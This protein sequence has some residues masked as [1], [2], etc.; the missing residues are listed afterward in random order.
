MNGSHDV[1]RAGAVGDGK[2]L[3]TAALQR[4]I[5]ACAD[6]GGGTVRV[7]AGIYRTGTL[8]LKSRVT[9]HLEAGATLLASERREDY[10]P[11]D[12]HPENPVF[13]REMVTGAHLIIAYRQQQVA[14]VGEGTIDGNGLAFFEPL[15][16]GEARA[17]Y[18]DKHRNFTIR[19]WRPGQ[20]IWGCLCTDVALRDVTLRN[21]PYWTCFLH[22]CRRVQVRG[23]RIQNPP[24]TP[25]GDGLDLDC[26]QDVTVSDCLIESGDD[27][28]TLRANAA[29]LGDEAMDCANVVVSNCVLRSPCNAIRVG[30]GDGIVRDCS[31]ANLV[32]AEARTGI[33][34]VACYSERSAHGARLENLRFANITMDTVMP[35]NVILGRHA[36]PP[37]MIRD[38]SFSHFSILARQGGYLGGN[39]DRPLENL[40]LHEVDLRLTGDEVDPEFRAED[41]RP[42]GSLRIPAGL[43]ACHVNGLRLDGVR[44][45][46]EQVAGA[47]R[48]ALALENCPDAELTRLE[49]GPPP[50]PAAGEAIRRD[51]AKG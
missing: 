19:D 10:N 31:L 51:G 44:V 43:H 8:Y 3:E 16:P 32:I 49:A 11:D 17:S 22:G 25:N 42:V 14:I 26:C 15:P 9:L 2:T 1:R 35:F 5:D 7:P 40:R 46:W 47:W 37:A 21:A 28:L 36:R 20:M 41:A 33:S 13:S 24:Q 48:H 4:A 29:P 50:L 23:L 18:R 6:A 27:C 45:R 30:V 38:L 39:S 34:V 12:I